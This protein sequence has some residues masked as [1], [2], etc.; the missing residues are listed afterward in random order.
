[1]WGRAGAAA[2]LPHLW[3]LWLRM[4]CPF[5]ISNKHPS[6]KVAMASWDF[7]SKFV[8]VGDVGTGKSSLLVQLT[9]QRFLADPDPTVGV[10]FGSYIVDIPETSERIK[11]QCW[12]TAGSEAFRSVSWGCKGGRGVAT[13]MARVR[14]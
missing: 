12:D 1:M 14:G 3:R 6:S 9:D 4:L 11:C 10:E 8:L 13:A 7:L 5:T 2:W